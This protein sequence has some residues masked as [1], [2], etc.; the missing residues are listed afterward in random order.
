MWALGILL[1]YMLYGKFPFR[2]NTETE[3]YR[4]IQQG[5]F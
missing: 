5:K 4:I 1:Y 2:A 3:L